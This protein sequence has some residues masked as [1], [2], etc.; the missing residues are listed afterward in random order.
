MEPNVVQDFIAAI[1]GAD[2]EQIC[3]LI[4]EDH[5]FVDSQG[6]RMSGIDNLRT[7]WTGYFG[8][9]PDYKI[10]ATELLQNDATVAVFGYAGATYRGS[11]NGTGEENHW[12][13]PAA[14][15]AVV[16]DGRIKLWQVY[17]DHSVVLEIFN[18]NRQWLQ[19]DI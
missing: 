10:E 2:V 19:R 8:L 13:I 3:R 18:R 15:R 6:N 16:A 11:C 4:S 17:A 1:N 9:F 5:T 14:W 7:A 12:R